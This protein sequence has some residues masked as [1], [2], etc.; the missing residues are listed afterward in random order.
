ML[1]ARDTIDSGIVTVAIS[2]ALTSS[3]YVVQS[4]IDETSNVVVN[5]V[6][7]SSTAEGEVPQQQCVIETQG[8]GEFGETV[9]NSGISVQTQISVTGA[10]ATGGIAGVN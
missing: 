6:L 2:S 9:I 1:A 3:A 4:E 7:S 8:G 5:A 10:T